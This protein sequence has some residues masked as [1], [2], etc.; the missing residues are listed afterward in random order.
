ML[1]RLTLD[2]LRALVAAGEEGS[3][4]AAGRRLGRAQSAVSQSVQIL[5]DELEVQLFDRSGK[6]PVLTEAGRAVLAHVL[7]HLDDAVVAG[8]PGWQLDH[9]GLG[10]SG[11]GRGLE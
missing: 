5:E 11:S 6:A 1:D 4:S 10:A 3:F 9:G 8:E 7:D 2:Q